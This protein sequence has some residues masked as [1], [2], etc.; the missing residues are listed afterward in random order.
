M[1]HIWNTKGGTVFKKIQEILA[2]LNQQGIHI[3]TIS[4]PATG[5]GSV[6]LTMLIISF[7]FCLISMAGKWSG[8][9][10]TIDPSQ[11][12]NLFMVCAGLY[13]GRKYQGKDVSLDK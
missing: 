3:P 1:Y 10:G 4:D 7:N 9:F 11:A 12:I 2:K 8:Y 13:F 6:S 5:K